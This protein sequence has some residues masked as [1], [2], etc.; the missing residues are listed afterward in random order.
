MRWK[1]CCLAVLASA[2]GPPGDTEALVLLDADA[3]AAGLTLSVGGWSGSPHM[4]ISVREAEQVI[5]SGGFG[6][7]ALPARPGQL[8]LVVGSAGSVDW[9]KV[10]EE[11]D[12]DALELI[13]DETAV[14]AVATTLGATMAREGTNLWKLRGSGVLERTAWMSVAGGIEQVRAVPILAARPLEVGGF[15]NLQR[16]TAV[17]LVNDVVSWVGVYRS[18]N[19]TLMLD[20]SGGFTLHAGCDVFAGTFRVEGGTVVL[21]TGPGAQRV[22]HVSQGSLVGFTPLEVAE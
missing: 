22:L 9:R 10:G 5:V 8:G 19:E 3:R 14:S 16:P 20:A 17:V 1:L 13:G 4:P 11:L 12:P 7:R 2:C 6:T 18:Q 15:S 21:Q